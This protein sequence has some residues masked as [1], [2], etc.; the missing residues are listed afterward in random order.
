MRLEILKIM[1]ILIVDDLY[2]NRLRMAIVL[3]SMGFRYDEASN[4]DEAIKLVSKNNYDLILMDIEMPV[5]NGIETTQYIREN[6]T[7]KKGKVSILAITAHNPEDFFNDHKNAGFNGLISKPLT[8]E[9]LEPY[10]KK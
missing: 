1:Q 8:R 5:R 7:G 4:G 6:F 2:T 9:K 3:R 10:L